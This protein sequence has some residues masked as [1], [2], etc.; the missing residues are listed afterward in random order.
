MRQGRGA[1]EELQCQKIPELKG[2][3]EVGPPGQGALV[4]RVGLPCPCPVPSLQEDH[5]PQWGMALWTQANVPS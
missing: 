4:H 3:Q 2:G 5:L 1:R